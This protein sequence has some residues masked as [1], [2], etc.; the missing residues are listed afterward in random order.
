MITESCVFHYDTNLEHKRERLSH[1][2]I[3]ITFIAHCILLLTKGIL[4]STLS[5]NR[6]FI[7]H[8]NCTKY[9]ARCDDVSKDYK[10]MYN[11]FV[12]L[13]IKL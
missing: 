8:R 9:M 7:I 11:I 4:F 1:Q 10:N 13:K 6:H 12:S 2:D 5:T 3:S